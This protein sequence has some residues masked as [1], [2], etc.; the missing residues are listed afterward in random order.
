M[1]KLPAA[2]M[3]FFFF[4]NVCKF[5]QVLQELSQ[6]S[7]EVF[8]R[9]K[10]CFLNRDTAHLTR[11]ENHGNPQGSE[12][13]VSALLVLRV[14]LLSAGLPE[15]SL[16]QTSSTG[17]YIVHSNNDAIANGNVVSFDPIRSAFHVLLCCPAPQG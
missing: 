9:V 12:V 3:L 16:V 14:D 11:G 6:T 2:F 1:D 5:Y 7:Y 4:S 17:S 8:Q 10:R 15:L 13:H